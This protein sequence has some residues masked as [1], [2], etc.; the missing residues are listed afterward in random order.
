MGDV[1]A[2][3]EEEGKQEKKEKKKGGAPF[4]QA[5]EA[6]AGGKK[7]ERD[8][9]KEAASTFHKHRD[10]FGEELMREA[11]SIEQ[12][13]RVEYEKAVA[14]GKEAILK[15]LKGKAV[16][17]KEGKREVRKAGEEKGDEKGDGKGRDEGK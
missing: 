11:R 13:A 14:R 15:G 10:V 7:E 2:T 17:R 1:F 4:A 3:K 16:A 5:K 8:A 6:Q 9:G 12:R